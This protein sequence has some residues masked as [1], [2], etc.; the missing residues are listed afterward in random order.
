MSISSISSSYVPSTI[1]A[2]SSVPAASSSPV[3]S[4]V[5]GLADGDQGRDE[6]QVSTLA[7]S[8]ASSSSSGVQA[9]LL[10]LQAG[11]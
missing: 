8:P 1:P 9:A 7:S 10:S 2:P 6:S 3:T 5:A 4:G 11:G